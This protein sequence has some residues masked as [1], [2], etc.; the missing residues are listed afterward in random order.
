MNNL[1]EELYDLEV[2]YDDYY[3]KWMREENEEKALEYSET[4]Y[5]IG[6]QIDDLKYKLSKIKDSEM[7]TYHF[8]IVFPRDT[9][10]PFGFIQLKG[11]TTKDAH[12]A[13]LEEAR[14]QG[15]DPALIQI[16]E[17]EV[18]TWLEFIVAA[19]KFLKT[20]ED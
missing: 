10:N 14:L 17:E 2:L 5:Q 12:N 3:R 7:I 1:T 18:K 8:V 15:E 20:K 9:K 13:A 11:E 6:E 16:K 19:E 4:V